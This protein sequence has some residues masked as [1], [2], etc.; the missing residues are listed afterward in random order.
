MWQ[1]TSGSAIQVWGNTPFVIQAGQ[2]YHVQILISGTGGITL[3]INGTE[4]DP[5]VTVPYNPFQ[6]QLHGWQPQNRWTVQNFTMGLTPSIVC[7]ADVVQAND[8]GQCSAVV[9]YP[10]PTTSAGATVISSPP[11]GSVFPVGTTTVSC[12]ASNDL[13]YTNN[14]SFKVTV[15][16]KEPPKIKCRRHGDI[17]VTSSRKPRERVVTYPAPKATDNC[18]IASIVCSPPSGSLFPVG[19]T[20]VTCT[21]TD[22]GDNTA[23]CQFVVNVRKPGKPCK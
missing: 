18:A 23:T 6:I 21:A 7:P 3:N 11:S 17:T 13:G 8:P 15:I 22:T 19:G 14:C 20:T 9:N 12:V 4:Y 16:D 5:G 2:T 10:A 1:L